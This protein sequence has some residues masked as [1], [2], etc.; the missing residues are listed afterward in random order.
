MSEKHGQHYF[1][2]TQQKAPYIEQ[3]DVFILLLNFSF[4]VMNGIKQ[5]MRR[6]SVIF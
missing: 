2:N 4:K 1:M 5:I 6:K 3:L